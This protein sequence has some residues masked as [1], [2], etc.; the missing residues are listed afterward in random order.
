MALASAN[1]ITCQRQV[2]QQRLCLATIDVD[3][4]FAVVYRQ[5]AQNVKPNG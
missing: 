3:E 5:C 2:N 1:G 4:R